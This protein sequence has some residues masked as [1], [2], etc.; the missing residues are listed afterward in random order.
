MNRV[1]VAALSLF[2]SLSANAE[3]SWLTDIHAIINEQLNDDLKE[4]AYKL[5]LKE[6]ETEINISYI[7]PRLELAPCQHKPRLDA[8]I[9]FKLG[10]LHIR[11]ACDGPSRWAINVPVEIKLL[12]NVV[13]FSRPIG[14]KTVISDD[15]LAYLEIDLGRLRNGY[16]LKSQ[17]V[18]GKQ[19]KRAVPAKQIVT[20]HLL[21]PALM[22]RKGDNVIIQAKN[23]QMSV[24]MAGEALADGR[25]GRQIRVKNRRSQ[26]IVKAKVV[27]PGLVEVGF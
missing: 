12:A 13:V 25:E 19:S 6:Y 26:R 22:I 4:L 3:E 18:I 24:K 10:R 16:F 20:P 8:P 2:I 15:D 7:D 11:I 9:P 14:K 27:A 17:D 23:N 1:F 21:Q 5:E